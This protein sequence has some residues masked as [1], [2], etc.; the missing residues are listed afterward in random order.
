[1]KKIK[2][3]KWVRNTLTVIAL[4][5]ALNGLRLLQKSFVDTCVEQGYS[6]NYCIEHS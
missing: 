2:L 3:K 5:V 1:M 6:V 4:I